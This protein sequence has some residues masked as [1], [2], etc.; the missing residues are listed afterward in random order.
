MPSHL[1]KIVVYEHDKQPLPQSLNGETTG[2]IG[3]IDFRFDTVRL[4]KLNQEDY[5]DTKV[6]QVAHVG[7]EPTHRTNGHFK[8]A[9]TALEYAGF[10]ANAEYSMFEN[11][12][13]LNLYSAL[14]Y[15]GYKPAKAKSIKV[16]KPISMGI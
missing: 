5:Q 11:I 6:L 8:Q 16:I 12:V 4:K 9:L 13:N 15:H 1:S 3:F 14:M 10:Q 7:I 2:E